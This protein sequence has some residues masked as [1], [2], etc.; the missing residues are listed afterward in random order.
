MINDNIMNLKVLINLF[1]G[2][3]IFLF[4]SCKAELKKEIIDEQHSKVISNDLLK[5]LG[6][7]TVTIETEAT[8]SGMASITYNFSISDSIVILDKTSYHEPLNCLGNYKAIEEDKILKLYYNGDEEYCKTKE[9]NFKLK[10]EGN[11][12]LMSGLGGEATF[13]EWIEIIKKQ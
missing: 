5:Y 3:F 13:N 7:F 11:K 9:P 10:K 8:A 1:T 6:N 2:V 4:C 12:F